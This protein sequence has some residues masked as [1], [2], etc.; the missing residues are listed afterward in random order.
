M[1]KLFSII[2]VA[3]MPFMSI[4]AQSEDNRNY[5]PEQGDMAFGVNVKPI[6]KYA[7]NI[8]NGNTNNTLDYLGGEPINANTSFD[9][10]I[11]PDV[12]IMSK[13][14]L[15]DSWGIRANVGLMFGKD[16][17]KR[18]IQD[19]KQIMLNP[20]DETKL[21]DTRYTS[22][23]GMSLMLGT[24]YR[25][26]NNRIQGVFGMGVLF[27]FFN[28]KISY[29]YANAVTS[30]NRNPSSAWGEYYKDYRV[31][32]YKI[33]GSMF[34]GITGSAGFEWFV[35]P[36]VSLGAEVNLCLYGISGGQEYT[37]SEGYNNVTE[38]FEQ[39]TDLTSPGDNKFRFGTE[40]LGG[41]LYMAFYF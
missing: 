34:Y 12:S 23:N 4:S 35:A 15:S 5:L 37:V 18:Y 3:L 16:T 10:E 41:S 36:K 2:A 17:D 39:R 38:K 11:L 40:N 24:E 28:E 22:R 9:N 19:D 6:F 8:F 30:L 29:N 21:I 26:G 7:G 31:V 13:Y 14:M 25:K 20:F 1:K 32:N 33:Q 27:G